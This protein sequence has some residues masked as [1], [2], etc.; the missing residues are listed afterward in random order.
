MAEADVLLLHGCWQEGSCQRQARVR[1]VAERDEDL[2]AELGA[3]TLP[4]E[5]A[6]ALLARCV[7]QLGGHECSGTEQIRDLSMGDR[8]ALLLHV[9]RMT[10]GE[11]IDCTLDCPACAE[12]MDFQLRAQELMV[13]TAEGPQP[14]YEEDFLLDGVKFRARFRLPTG[15]DVETVLRTEHGDPEQAAHALLFRCVEWIH[16]LDGGAGLSGEAWP[17]ELVAQITAR[18]SE[19]DPQSEIR[20][21]LT[22]P[23]CEHV[24]EALFDTSDYFLRELSSRERRLYEDVHQLALA[25]HWSEAEILQMPPRRRKVYLDL[26]A[27]E[28]W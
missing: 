8:E 1:G 26:L 9:R 11:R 23:A 7:T 24:F 27:G 20:L 5:R 16:G 28:R 12:R 17:V 25:Y 6:T 13:S 4:V 22:C 19:L 21:Q 10:F 14:R 18:M 2:A 3:A 15:T